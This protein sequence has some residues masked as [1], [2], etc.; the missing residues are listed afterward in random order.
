MLSESWGLKSAVMSAYGDT[1]ENQSFLLCG[2]E[3][4]DLV[5]L[6]ALGGSRADLGMVAAGCQR[7][8]LQLSSWGG[9]GKSQQCSCF[10]VILPLYTLAS[11]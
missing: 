5:L 4:Q 10:K 3:I 8:A 11:S 7:G 9:H 2:P 1:S 6:V